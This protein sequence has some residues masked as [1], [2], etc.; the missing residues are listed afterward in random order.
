MGAAL[1]ARAA[2]A[3]LHHPRCTRATGA[4]FLLLVFLCRP[5]SLLPFT[6][7]HEMD[8]STLCSPLSSS[9]RNPTP[10]VAQNKATGGTRVYPGTHRNASINP[11]HSAGVELVVFYIYRYIPRE[12]CSQFDLLPLTSLTKGV[13]LDMEAGDAI[14]FDGLL[15]HQGTENTTASPPVERYFY[16][17]AVCTG[18]DPN[19]EVTGKTATTSAPK[20]RKAKRAKVAAVQKAAALTAAPAATEEE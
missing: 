8:F 4:L 13:E 9:R 10:F 12:S 6:L 2:A 3:L 14:I 15:Q 16:Y 19:T 18:E 5:N 11:P 20:R 1:H 17:V 7:R